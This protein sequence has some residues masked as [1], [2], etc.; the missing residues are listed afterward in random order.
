M[1]SSTS[2][3]KNLFHQNTQRYIMQKDVRQ[4]TVIMKFGNITAIFGGVFLLKL[5]G[6]RPWQSQASHPD[7]ATPRGRRECLPGVLLQNQ[8]NFSQKL[9]SR[10]PLC[11]H[12]TYL[13]SM[14][15]T[16]PIPSKGNGITPGQWFSN[17]FYHGTNSGA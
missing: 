11:S 15:L 3:S 5:V 17:I 16:T 10:V 2:N 7:T 6:R 14:N 1:I 8:K 13:G 4:I 12:W 9:P